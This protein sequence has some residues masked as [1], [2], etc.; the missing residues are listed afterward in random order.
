MRPAELAGTTAFRLSLML[1]LVLVSGAVGLCGF[2]YWQFSAIT[3][4]ELDLRIRV[5]LAE[6]VSGGA[7]SQAV[8][9][10][11]AEGPMW[12][13]GVF[14]PD[15]TSLS[16]NLL[17]IP[18]G[19]PIDAAIHEIG[20]PGGGDYPAPI[21]FVARRLEDGR[22]LVLGHD[23]D[24]LA[25]LREL[26]RHVLAGGLIISVA[27]SLLAG[28]LLSFGSLRRIQTMHRTAAAI[29]RG[30]LSRR[31][32]VGRR[33]DDLD[34]LARIVNDML[35]Q[36]E[37]LIA[38]LKAAGDNIAHDLRTP[39]TYLR[40]SLEL[41]AR[42]PG[43]A[44]ERDHAIADA[45]AQVDRILGIFQAL[46]RVSE[47][48]DGKRRSGFRLVSLS[49]VAT[50]VVELYEPVA[51]DR[52]QG[53][54]LRLTGRSSILGDRDLL[55]D[56]LSNL[57]DNAI[58]FTPEGGAVSVHVEDRPGVHVLAVEDT[59]PGIPAELRTR[60]FQRFARGDRARNTRGSGLGLSLV[61][62][63]ARLHDAAIDLH[64][65]PASFCIAVAFPVPAE[66]P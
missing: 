56:L 1:G 57:V 23:T 47:V 13:V 55:F 52:G 54:Q 51:A 15:G 26:V 9:Q 31:L 53:L 7:S 34:K 2:I 25:R 5:E 50:A 39:L 45:I 64:Q 20:T 65:T 44:A 59:G 62:A 8:A 66:A 22:T 21:R 6:I 3:E 19:L 48:E 60:L 43:T 29:M 41:S 40:T 58:K 32:P 27:G 37:T 14:A 16:G 11:L 30:D 33:R 28:A 46:L 42:T 12:S 63:I 38:G 35:D 4:H 61:A 49:E 18:D 36:I 10:Q 17:A 24:E